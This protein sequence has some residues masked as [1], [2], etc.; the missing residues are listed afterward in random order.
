[1]STTKIYNELGENKLLEY[2]ETET[3]YIPG[4]K[5]K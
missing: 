1:M 5:V 4:N 2:G 3:I